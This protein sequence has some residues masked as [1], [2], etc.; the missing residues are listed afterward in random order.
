ML[1][2]DMYNKNITPINFSQILEQSFCIRLYALKLTF[3]KLLELNF[4]RQ[5]AYFSRRKSKLHEKTILANY[6]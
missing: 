5:D 6:V 4:C 3:G 1:S 2:H